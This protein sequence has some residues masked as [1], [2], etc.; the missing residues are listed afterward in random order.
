MRRRVLAAATLAVLV[1]GAGV[2]LAS[3]A[4]YDG[5]IKGGGKVAFSVK[6]SDGARKISRFDFRHLAVKCNGRRQGVTGNLRKRYSPRVADDGSFR[7]RADNGFGGIV[8]VNGKLKR[9]ARARGTIRADGS[10]T[11]DRTGRKKK[12][13]HSRVSDWTARR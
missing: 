6:R 3:T 11:V 12:H 4:K 1:V 9:H 8:R 10:F 13:C 7:I 5:A 2:A